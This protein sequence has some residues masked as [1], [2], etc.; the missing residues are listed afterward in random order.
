MAA[1]L[2][3]SPDKGNHIFSDPH[4]RGPLALVFA[5]NGHLLTANGDAVNGDTAHP[6]EIVVQMSSPW[7]FSFVHAISSIYFDCRSTI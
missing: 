5:P 2:P 3:L 7:R 4:L 1:C 6:S